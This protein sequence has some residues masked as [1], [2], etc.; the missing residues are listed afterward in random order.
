MART[1]SSNR[2]DDPRKVF[3]ARD[4]RAGRRLVA[5]LLIGSGLGTALWRVAGPPSVPATFDLTNVWRTLTESGL[6]DSEVIT[7][8]T[9]IAWGLLGYLALTTALRAILIAAEPAT[10]GARWARTA[11]GFSNLITLPAV[12]RIVDGGIAGTL[13]M[14]SW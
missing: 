10:G 13:L 4:P 7:A 1:L 6:S 11:L 3:S 14:S 12:R 8:G 5:L 2:H 9:W